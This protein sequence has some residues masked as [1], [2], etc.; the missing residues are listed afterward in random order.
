M[1][2]TADQ[3]KPKVRGKADFFSWQLYRYMK[4]YSNPVHHRIWQGVWNTVNG[5]EPDRTVLYIGDPMDCGFIHCC[6]L[7]QLCT[8]NGK[9]ERFAYS[10]G[11]HVSKWVDITD[12]WWPEYLQKGVC[13]IHGDWAH[14]WI[15]NGD[16]R[17]CEYCGKQERK[18]VEMIPKETWVAA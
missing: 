9:I 5:Y 1:I 14:N 4:K 3:I 8:I 11:H 15:E 6:N 16:H 10:H 12:E 18:T 2:P 17:S 7:K 13:A